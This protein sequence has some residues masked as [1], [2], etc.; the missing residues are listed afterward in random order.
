[1]EALTIE[2]PESASV[3][4]A[5]PSC[6]LQDGFEHQR[7]VAGRRIDDLQHLRGRGL[8]GLGLVAFS[9]SLLKLGGPLV[10]PQTQLR[11][12][13]PKLSDLIFQR[14]GHVLLRRTLS[15][16][17]DTRVSFRLHARSMLIF[18]FGIEIPTATART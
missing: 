5:Q 1:M 14:R 7:E 16:S 17:Y 18:H 15:W 10:E 3:S 12:G 9:R 11:V 2:H 4:L 13:T 6:F 8:L